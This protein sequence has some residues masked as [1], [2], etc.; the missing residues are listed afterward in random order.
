MFAAPNWLARIRMFSTRVY[1][2]PLVDG[3]QFSVRD[4]GLEGLE[5]VAGANRSPRRC[6]RARMKAW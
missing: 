5:I 2:D 3:G 6:L 1:P 4:S